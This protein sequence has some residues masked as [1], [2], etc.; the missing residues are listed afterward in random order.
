MHVDWFLGDNSQAQ[1]TNLQIDIKDD[2][3]LFTE[4]KPPEYTT[5]YKPVGVVERQ[6]ITE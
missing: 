1:F 4:G 6:L 3:K 2:A 5:K